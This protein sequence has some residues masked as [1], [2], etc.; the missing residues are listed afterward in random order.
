MEGGRQW[1]RKAA[2]RLLMRELASEIEILK[3]EMRILNKGSS[4]CSRFCMS[5]AGESE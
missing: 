2:T 5:E 1:E 4:H 3:S